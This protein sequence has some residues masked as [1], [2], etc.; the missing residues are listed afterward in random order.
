MIDKKEFLKELYLKG[1][2]AIKPENS[3]RDSITLDG[4]ILKIADKSYDLKSYKNIYLYGSGKASI[5]MAKALR[6]IVGDIF[7]EIFVVSN[8]HEDIDGIRV[9]KSTH[10]LP[11]QLSLEAGKLL[12]DKF[13]SLKEDDL[14]IYLLSGGTS[15]L[16]EDLNYFNKVSYKNPAEMLLDDLKNGILIEEFIN[17]SKILIESGAKIDEINSVRKAISNIK[18]GGLARVTKADGFVLVMSDVVGDDL[19]AIGSAPFI[20]SSSCNVF[21]ILK[22]YNLLEK[23]PTIFKD[24]IFKEKKCE[25]IKKF[26]H[27]IV[28]SN[29]IALEAIKKEAIKSGFSAEIVSDS[30]EGDVNDVA[31]YIVSERKRSNKDILIFG[32]ESTVKVLGSGIGGRNSELCLRVLKQ[33]GGY[34]DFTFLSAG[35]DGIDGVSEGAGGIVD[36]GD[37]D[38]SIDR[39]LKNSDSYSYLK[40]KNS[41][42]V[43][44]ESGVNVMD[45]MIAMK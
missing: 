45:I 4:D 16:I 34:D 25:E 39:Y 13:S 17:F 30:V 44:G 31:R 5:K 18:G 33:M 15:A 40:L 28:S 23:L 37:L 35:S 10:P 21:E 14:F 7:K 6:D 43:T 1:I 9:F 22:K 2:D 38:D 3:L 29:K 24:A 36:I 8:Y 11:S 26:D 41:A 42:I 20:C 27:F 32:G 12:L 19:D